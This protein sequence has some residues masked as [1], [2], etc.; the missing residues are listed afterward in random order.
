MKKWLGRVLCVVGWH[1]F[2]E[3]EEIYGRLTC[4]RGCGIWTTLGSLGL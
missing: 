4:R 2:H 3:D 1:D